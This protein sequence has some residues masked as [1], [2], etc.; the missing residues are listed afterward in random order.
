M[1]RDFD[2]EEKKFVPKITSPIYFRM[3]N[4]PWINPPPAEKEQNRVPPLTESHH[5]MHSV[6]FNL[7]LFIHEGFT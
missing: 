5:H 7:S 2:S 4:A 3:A 1:L 6:L